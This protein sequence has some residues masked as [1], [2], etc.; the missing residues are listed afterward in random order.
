MKV[1][2]FAVI[3]KSMKAEIFGS[4]P[5]NGQVVYSKNK[6]KNVTLKR[7]RTLLMK[8]NFNTEVTSSVC[9]SMPKCMVLGSYTHNSEIQNS[10]PH[11]QRS[12]RTTIWLK[13]NGLVSCQV[14]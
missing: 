10:L 13:I 11:K 12:R 1:R 6:T 3:I 5:S 4:T 9:T 2:D 7:K 14:A 8:S